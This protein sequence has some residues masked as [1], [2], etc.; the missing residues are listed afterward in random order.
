MGKFALLQLMAIVLMLAACDSQDPTENMTTVGVIIVNQGNFADGNGSISVYDPETKV[1]TTLLSG[2][3]SILQSILVK[4]DV[5]YVAANSSARIELVQLSTGQRAGQ[6]TGLTS[7]RYMIAINDNTVYVTNLFKQGFVGGTV[8]IVDMTTNSVVKTLDVGDNPEGVAYSAERLYVANSGFGLGSTLSVI[9]TSA[10]QVI[11]TVDVG[12]NGP[13]SLQMDREDEL[14]VMCTGGTLFDDDFNVIGETPGEIVIVDGPTGVPVDSLQ[15][16]D[17][18]E[19]VGPGQDSFYSEA[20]QELYVVVDQ[21]RVMRINTGANTLVDTLGPFSGDPIG[22]VA[23]DATTERL[24]LG[25]VPSFTEAGTVTVHDR[26][27]RE[28]ET[29]FVGV[30]PTHILFLQ[31]E[32]Q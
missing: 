29:F 20:A 21:K 25:R 31:E 17:Q 4:N 27:G 6:I 22:A 7:P 16:A 12:C 1:T 11:A 15:L 14:W 3:G 30:A 32:R 28:L 5:G 23:Y 13:R 19:T 8:S 9:D 10:E 26:N 2:V 18:I 24:Y